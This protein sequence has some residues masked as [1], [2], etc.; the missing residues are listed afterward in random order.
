MRKHVHRFLCAQRDLLSPA[1]IA[2]GQ[3]RAAG[4]DRALSTPRGHGH[5]QN[6]MEELE[7]VANKW[8][9]PYPHATMRENVEVLSGRAGGGDGHP[10]VFFAAVQDSHRLD[11]ADALRRDIHARFHAFYKIIFSRP[12]LK[13]EIRWQGEQVK[14][15]RLAGNSTGWERI[16]EWFRRISYVHVVAQNGWQ[17]KS[18]S[19]IRF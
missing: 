14:I 15:A 9:K 7:Q 18:I 17:L 5:V 1:A 3:R 10:H 6:K 2:T 4:I 11:A 12:D 16:K 13:I 8:L 19:P